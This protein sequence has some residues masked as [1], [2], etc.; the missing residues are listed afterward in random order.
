MIS[1]IV[2]KIKGLVTNKPEFD[3]GL[4]INITS[5]QIMAMINLNDKSFVEWK[6]PSANCRRPNFSITSAESVRYR[7]FR[8]SEIDVQI[9][10]SGVFLTEN[11]VEKGSIS[12]FHIYLVTQ[13][14]FVW[15][16]AE[17]VCPFGWK[18]VQR[19]SPEISLITKHKGDP[20][21]LKI[22]NINR[23]DNYKDDV[24]I[25]ICP[26]AGSGRLGNQI[27][28][29]ICNILET[30]KQFRPKSQSSGSAIGSES[31][32]VRLIF[33]VASWSSN[34]KDHQSQ[35][36]DK[37]GVTSTD[38]NQTGQADAR[39][40]R[41]SSFVIY[42]FCLSEVFTSVAMRPLFNSC[43]LEK[44]NLDLIYD[45]TVYNEDFDSISNLIAVFR[46]SFT[47]NPFILD[48]M[49]INIHLRGG[50]FCYV[51]KY[52]GVVAF[53]YYWR[54]LLKCFEASTNGLPQTIVIFH[55]P[56]D[57]Y[58]KDHLALY[59][60]L[61]I[62]QYLNAMSDE[63]NTAGVRVEI[64]SESQLYPDAS[65]YDIANI[66]TSTSNV[67]IASNSTFSSMALLLNA[68]KDLRFF[69]PQSTASITYAIFSN[70]KSPLLAS[71][72]G[73][74]I[75]D[76]K[77]FVCDSDIRYVEM[78]V[79]YHRLHNLKLKTLGLT[80]VGSGQRMWKYTEKVFAKNNK[81][82]PIPDCM[83]DV[84]KFKSPRLL[85][86]SCFPRQ[87]VNCDHADNIANC[88]LYFIDEILS[89]PDNNNQS[90]N[91]TEQQSGGS[92]QTNYQGYV[93][94][95]TIILIVMW[96]GYRHR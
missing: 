66:M 32:R 35:T 89:Q 84:Y 18:V 44:L 53:E 38:Q 40:L 43:G 2:A 8:P 91:S 58:L 93:S 1:I 25:V 70:I 26:A 29:F 10:E 57:A 79:G 60:R 5:D 82:S 19:L 80:D 7:K 4:E 77:H 28:G 39:W 85:K 95:L 73:E 22:E 51:N 64:F 31:Q 34:W 41:F 42:N 83:A 55:Q 36:D 75:E 6:N 27:M 63:S 21:A 59:L 37:F 45:P 16:T 12:R 15:N 87:N 72:L 3:H 65:E 17:F 24:L 96:V 90:P 46:Q 86:T 69:Q 23:N 81:E 88:Y 94:V 61:K 56:A 30:I 11:N 50:D 52:F 48:K 54:A 74:R 49:Q 92:R 62:D 20:P 14:C 9:D 67:V 78:L 71:S 76:C 68:N 13:K 47:L 33:G